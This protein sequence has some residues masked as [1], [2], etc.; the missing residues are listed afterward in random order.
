MNRTFLLALSLGV[1]LGPAAASAGPRDDVLQALGKCAA[2]AESSARLSCY[3]GLAPQLKAALA[4]APARFSG[5][6]SLEQQKSWF[7]FSLDSL[8]G[9]GEAPQSTPAQFGGERVPEAAKPAETAAPAPPP[10]L[11]SITAKLSEYA[12][13]PFGKF[14]V[15][16]DNGQVW[17][18]L[19]GDSGEARFRR[20]ATDNTVTISRAIFGSYTLKLNDSNKTYKVERLK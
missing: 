4:T 9:G 18:Q 6:P 20:T 7:G 13:T 3:D 19:Q 2:I 8:F 11:D 5:T 16:L 14:I 17:R 15:F 12:K 1:F 10:R